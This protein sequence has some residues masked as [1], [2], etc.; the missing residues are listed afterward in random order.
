MSAF[1]QW[2]VSVRPRL[3]NNKSVSVSFSEC[4][5]AATKYVEEKFTSA[6]TDYTAALEWELTQFLTDRNIYDGEKETLE[7]AKRLNSVVRK[8]Q[9]NCA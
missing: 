5:D 3:E 7:L 1:E 4:W 9:Q 8:Q 2:F 6:N